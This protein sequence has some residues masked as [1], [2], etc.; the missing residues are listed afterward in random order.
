VGK[1][2]LGAVPTVFLIERLRAE[3][4]AR[5]S[6]AHSRPVGFGPPYA[7]RQ[8]AGNPAC[9]MTKRWIGGTTTI[10]IGTIT[11]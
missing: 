9:R 10:N 5:S 8:R 2:A 11:T 4:W 1:G 3:W 6:G 7:L